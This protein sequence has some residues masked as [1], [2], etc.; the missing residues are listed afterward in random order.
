MLFNIEDKTL[1]QYEPTSNPK[2]IN[3]VTYSYADLDTQTIFNLES[4]HQ[5]VSA[6][7]FYYDDLMLN[8]D[9]NSDASI[10]STEKALDYITSVI[11]TIVENNFTKLRVVS[12]QER[13]A[14][15]F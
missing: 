2:S 10:I 7:E 5:T 15:E 14:T 12:S 3:K 9:A 13:F 8:S 6:L 4:Y 11:D 1:V